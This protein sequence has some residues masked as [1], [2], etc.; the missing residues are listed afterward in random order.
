[1]VKRFKTPGDSRGKKTSFNLKQ[2][3]RERRL[4]VF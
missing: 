2:L 3:R 4:H 1:V